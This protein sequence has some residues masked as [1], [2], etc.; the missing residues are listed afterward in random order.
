MRANFLAAIRDSVS[1]FAPV[2]T[3]LP[4][5]NMRLVVRG[6]RILIITAANRFGLYSALRACIAI[7]LSSSLHDKLTVLTIFCNCGGC[8]PI[9]IGVIALL[10]GMVDGGPAELCGCKNVACFLTAACGGP[11]VGWDDVEGPGRSGTPENIS[12]Q[13]YPSNRLCKFDLRL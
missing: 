3:I 9:D 8:T 7:F 6:S 13:K 11:M 2:H 5:L 10:G 12:K 4:L 1:L